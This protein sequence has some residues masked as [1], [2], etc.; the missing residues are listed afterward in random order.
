MIQANDPARPALKV[1]C[2]Q[3]DPE[4]G[5]VAKNLARASE[6]VR[7]AAREIPAP[8][9]DERAAYGRWV[10]DTVGMTVLTAEAEQIS[11][12]DHRWAVRTSAG[13]VSADG[14]IHI[15]AEYDTL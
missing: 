1:S 3:F 12:D 7:A 2:I 10:A 13:T 14:G 6:L 8:T 15:F 9:D 5:A 11:V 4:F